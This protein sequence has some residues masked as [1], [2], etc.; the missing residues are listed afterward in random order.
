MRIECIVQQ[1][2]IQHD[3][4]FEMDAFRPVVNKKKTGNLNLNL[5]NQNIINVI[6]LC[7]T[8]YLKVF[9]SCLMIVNLLYIHQITYDFYP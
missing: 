5:A 9:S 6:M 8:K 4:S 1:N 7:V 3:L 2:L